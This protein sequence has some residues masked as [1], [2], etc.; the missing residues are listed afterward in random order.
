MYATI[1]FRIPLSKPGKKG[2]RVSRYEKLYRDMLLILKQ[3]GC[4]VSV[5]NPVT[6]KNHREGDQRVNY[7]NREVNASKGTGFIHSPSDSF[8]ISG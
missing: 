4:Q 5:W 3:L 7:T 8:G 6:D 1:I 2:K